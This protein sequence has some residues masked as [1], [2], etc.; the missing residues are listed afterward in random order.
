VNYSGFLGQPVL[1]DAD[2]IAFKAFVTGNGVDSTNDTGIWLERSGSLTLV[3][4]EGDQPPGTPDGAVVGS[5][6]GLSNRLVLNDAGQVA[7]TNPNGLWATDRAG[8]L[9]LIARTGDLLEVAPGDF[10]TIRLP[11]F[12]P[13]NGI[14]T[15][16]SDGRPSFFNNRG[17]L[18]FAATF[19]D[20]SSGIFVSNRVA[21]PEPSTCALVAL[22][23][24]AWIAT[25]RRAGISSHHA[26]VQ[27]TVGDCP[28][29]AE[30]SEQIG[31]VPLPETV[32]G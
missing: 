22:G 17:Q 10:R 26:L 3:A 24:V 28:K 7:F 9:Q 8:E 25:P 21:I 12:D 30:S 27:R 31:T 4:R 13:S 16:N 19:T 18:A 15:G 32:L 14:S 2:Q 6:S 11:F 20:G 5:F 29:F 23:C 1:N